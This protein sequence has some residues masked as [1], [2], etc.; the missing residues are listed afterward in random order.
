MEHEIFQGV[1]GSMRIRQQNM[2]SN[3]RGAK[4]SS[5]YAESLEISRRHTKLLEVR[6]QYDISKTARKENSFPKELR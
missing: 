2:K 3:A 6:K 1:S 5:N 4:P